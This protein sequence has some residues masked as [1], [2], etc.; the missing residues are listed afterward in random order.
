MGCVAALR[1]RSGDGLKISPRLTVSETAIEG[2]IKLNYPST[3][4]ISLTHFSGRLFQKIAPES[5]DAAGLV[6]VHKVGTSQV[7]RGGEMVLS[8]GVASPPVCTADC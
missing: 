4:S 7:P 8:A 5:W 1:F 6:M 3:S 2:V